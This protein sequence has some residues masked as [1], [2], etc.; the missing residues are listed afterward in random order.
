[1]DDP[2]SVYL[3]DHL[4]GSKFAIELLEKLSTSYPDHEA[5]VVAGAVL[6]Q[7]QQDQ[8]TL[9][10]IIDRV[11]RSHL[12]LKDASAWIAEKVSRAK[13]KH[14][15]PEGLGAFEAFEALGLGI[16]GKMA[17]WHALSVVAQTDT[18][19]TGFDYELLSSRAK[20]QFASIEAFRLGMAA[21]TF[22]RRP[23]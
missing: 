3:H 10:Q 19:M 21:T 20:E 16:L 9:Q 11:G 14:D 17:L 23:G 2:L 22:S 12:D 6:K 8:I 5:G 13:L 1:M 15:D 4:A 7:V 18:R